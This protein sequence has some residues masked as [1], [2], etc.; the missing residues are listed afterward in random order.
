MFCPSE[1]GDPSSVNVFQNMTSNLQSESFYSAMSAPSG[2]VV[3]PILSKSFQDD[4]PPPA[5]IAVPTGN[6]EDCCFTASN[7]INVKIITKPASSDGK[8]QHRENTEIRRNASPPPS[9]S[10][11]SESIDR[12][13]N[14]I[15]NAAGIPKEEGNRLK[16]MVMRRQTAWDRSLNNISESPSTGIT[17]FVDF[18]DIRNSISIA[19]PPL[20]KQQT[21]IQSHRDSIEKGPVLYDQRSSTVSGPMTRV[22]VPQTQDN[23]FESILRYYLA[24]RQNGTG[25]HHQSSNS[26]IK[27]V[28]GA[29][30]KNDLSTSEFSV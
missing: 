12:N 19:T 18:G 17:S 8:A 29:R 14:M 9:S 28:W 22:A 3:K 5:H 10:R 25:I 24:P 20:P 30:S 27:N 1:S 26:R 2:T 16:R 13:F 11:S 21:E 23:S 7:F 4:R 15:S 6:Q